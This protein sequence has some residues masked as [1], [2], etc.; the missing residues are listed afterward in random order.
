MSTEKLELK[1][2]G[3]TLLAPE[4]VK[5]Q[6]DIAWLAE[7][8]GRR[9]AMHIRIQKSFGLNGC[10]IKR[11]P[12]STIVAL[13]FVE[14]NLMTCLVGTEGVNSH[15]LPYRCMFNS[16]TNS[17]TWNIPRLL[18]PRDRLSDLRGWY[19]IWPICLPEG[20]FI[21]LIGRNG[22]D[23]IHVILINLTGAGIFE[24]VDSISLDEGSFTF[25]GAIIGKAEH[26][27]FSPILE[28]HQPYDISLN[29][30]I[31]A[32]CR[33]MRHAS[34][35][36]LEKL[37]RNVSGSSGYPGPLPF[38][39]LSMSCHGERASMSHEEGIRQAKELFQLVRF[40]N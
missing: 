37:R 27:I 18:I 10:D 26:M 40:N 28:Q 29:R 36:A 30:E 13:M 38:L 34:L 25:G 14:G 20:D 24:G 17:L 6:R 9:Q 4:Q 31:V 16:Y 33:L 19:E 11:D 7:V 2:G 35:E 1:D 32:A 8:G 22:R 39:A 12:F 15:Q 21:A 3:V 5:G 23:H